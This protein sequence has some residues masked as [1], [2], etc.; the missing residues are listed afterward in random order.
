[1]RGRDI[2]GSDILVVVSICLMSMPSPACA[3][4]RYPDAKLLAELA[5]GSDLNASPFGTT[6]KHEPPA[7]IASPT[8]INFGRVRLRE[9]TSVVVTLVNP[10][11][12]PLTVR[13]VSTGNLGDYFFGSDVEPGRWVVPPNGRSQLTV[14]FAPKTAAQIDSTLTIETDASVGAF[15]R[16]RLTG[17]G[18][19]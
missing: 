3:G 17:I 15:T 14:S 1:M 11:N 6:N 12:A 19:R 5:A 10:T 4:R 7:L 9:D 13:W 8:A 18:T 2:G 16:L